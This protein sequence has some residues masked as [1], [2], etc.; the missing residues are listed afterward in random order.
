LSKKGGRGFPYLVYMDADGQV[1]GKPPGRSVKAFAKGIKGAQRYL[2]LQKKADKTPEEQVELFEL[3]VSYGKL[4]AAAA[5]AKREQLK[6]PPELDAKLE[7]AIGSLEAT[8]AVKEAGKQLRSRADVQSKGPEIGKGFYEKFHSKGIV[9]GDPQI[10]MQFY[11]LIMEYGFQK[12]V[13]AAAESAVEAL[14]KQLG[15]NPRARGFLKQ[16]E[17][18]LSKLKAE[19]A[20][21]N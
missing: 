4:D 2:T 17:T 11:F 14:K 5:K 8:A 16:L 6:L 20:G 13:V 10:R 1:L 3:E 7:K 18:R 19:G 15:S 12:K 21:G 9:P